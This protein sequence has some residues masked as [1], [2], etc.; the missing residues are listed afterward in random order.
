MTTQSEEMLK[1]AQE[2]WA[3]AL[4]A[5]KQSVIDFFVLDDSAKH[6][7]AFEFAEDVLFLMQ[8][9]RLVFADEKVL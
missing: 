8:L 6:D 1:K 9:G 5:A 2:H 7:K 4:D 3:V